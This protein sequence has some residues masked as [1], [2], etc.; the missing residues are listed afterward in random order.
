MT[1]MY[2]PYQ[3]VLVWVTYPY[4]SRWKQLGFIQL[5]DKVLVFPHKRK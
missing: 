2:H 5:N 1:R 3:G 4:V